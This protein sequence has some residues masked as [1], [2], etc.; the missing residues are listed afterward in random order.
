MLLELLESRHASE[1]KAHQSGVQ[2]F[3]LK[4]HAQEEFARRPS[5]AADSQCNVTVQGD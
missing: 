2:D 4:I 3:S 1:D 5:P